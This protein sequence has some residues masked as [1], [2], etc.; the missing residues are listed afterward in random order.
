M[1]H[2]VRQVDVIEDPAAAAVALDPVRAR[3]LAESCARPPRSDRT[4]D[5]RGLTRDL[6]EQRNSAWQR[7]SVVVAAIHPTIARSCR[8]KSRQRTTAADWSRVAG[9]GERSG[10]IGFPQVGPSA[11]SSLAHIRVM[12]AM[13]S[14]L[15][16]ST[17]YFLTE[18]S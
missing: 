5:G 7:L 6:N 17:K 15:R 1:L 3:L 9:R 12:A 11:L 2:D 14:S 4:R 13:S 10:R 16:G 18:S 8:P